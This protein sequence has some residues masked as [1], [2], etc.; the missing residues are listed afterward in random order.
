MWDRYICQHGTSLL[1]LFTASARL[2]SAAQVGK[3]YMQDVIVEA[4]WYNQL[5]WS[6]MAKLNLAATLSGLFS[7][8]FLSVCMQPFD[9]ARTRLYSQPVNPDGTGKLYRDGVKGMVDVFSQTVKAEGP[10]GLYKG[11]GGNMLRQGPHMAITFL[12]L[13]QFENLYRTTVIREEELKESYKRIDT[14]GNGITVKDLLASMRSSAAKGTKQT[15]Q[16]NLMFDGSTF[17]SQCENG[18]Q[19]RSELVFDGDSGRDRYSCGVTEAHRENNKIHVH[20]V[21]RGPAPGIHQYLPHSAS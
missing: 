17:E 11:L 3:T 21:A 4:N 6:P 5:D 19:Y 8:C 10:V 1:L 13:Q 20:Y 12:I 16:E 15:V 18:Y 7:G 14:T 2:S 9:T